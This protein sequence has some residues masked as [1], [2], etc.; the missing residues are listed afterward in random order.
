MKEHIVYFYGSTRIITG[1]NSLNKLSVSQR[2]QLIGFEGII[3]NPDLVEL[4][5]TCL[6]TIN[7]RGGHG[8]TGTLFSENKTIVPFRYLYNEDLIISHLE[9]VITA[10]E[11]YIK[12]DIIRFPLMALKQATTEGYNLLG[13]N[14]SSSQQKEIEFKKKWCCYGHYYLNLIIRALFNKGYHTPESTTNLLNTEFNGP[15]RRKLIIHADA[16]L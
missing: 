13:L 12:A 5:E 15:N 6:N 3:V 7:P 4:G 9:D 2:N 11:Q 1:H 16:G 8:E 14:Y 10:N